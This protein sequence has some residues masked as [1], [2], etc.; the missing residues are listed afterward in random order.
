MYHTVLQCNFNATRP[1]SA[2][3]NAAP[4]EG[5][6]VGG[7]G[8]GVGGVGEPPTLSPTKTPHAR[9]RKGQIKGLQIK[10]SKLVEV[11][12]TTPRPNVEGHP[13][14]GGGGGGWGG[15]GGGF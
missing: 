1:A 7:G 10:G 8:G 14:R 15:V 6:D 13:R 3:P 2:W 11:R 5:A 9:A 4:G 12:P